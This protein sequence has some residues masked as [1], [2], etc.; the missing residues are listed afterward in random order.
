MC[1]PKNQKAKS[2]QRKFDD[3]YTNV[4][5]ELKPMTP[6]MFIHNKPH[7]L[8]AKPTMF[9]QGMASND[10][11][12]KGVGWLRKGDVFFIV[13]EPV[14]ENFTSNKPKYLTLK[15]IG[16][17]KEVI[18]YMVLPVSKK[19]LKE[20]ANPL[21]QEVVNDCEEEDKTTTTQTE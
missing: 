19:A 20:Y 15:I 9:D 21:F 18:G 5:G 10:P 4:I 17:T 6:Y 11:M 3:L 13:Q 12:N 8:C 14:K 7:V 16:S 1:G 2:T